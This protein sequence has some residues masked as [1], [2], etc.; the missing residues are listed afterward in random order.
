MAFSST[1]AASP[2]EALGLQ[3]PW[4]S[5]AVPQAGTQLPELVYPCLA[6]RALFH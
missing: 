3:E 6:S 1:V 4:S 5:R 2:E